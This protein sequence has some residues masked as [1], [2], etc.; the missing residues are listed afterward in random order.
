MKKNYIRFLSIFLAVIAL[1]FLVFNFGINFWLQNNLAG[2]IKKNSQYNVAYNDLKVDIVTGDISAS[3]IT[4]ENKKDANPNII[5]LQGHVD[6]LSISRLGIYDAVFHKVIN[7]SQLILVH[8]DLKITLAKPVD[9]KTGKKKESGR[10]RKFN[11]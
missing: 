6:S 4:I 2:Y 8:P 3:A 10:F 7:S 9:D 11:H 1:I 5:G